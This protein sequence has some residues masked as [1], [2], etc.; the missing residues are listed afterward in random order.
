LGFEATGIQGELR[1]GHQRAAHIRDWRIV[2][3]EDMLCDPVTVLTGRLETRNSFWMA[4]GKFS[5]RLHFN[6]CTWVWEV[7]ELK[8]SDPLELW[9]Y[10]SPHSLGG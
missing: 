3:R 10:N 6:K 9:L 1:V 8:S 7:A 2:K 4:H 5:V